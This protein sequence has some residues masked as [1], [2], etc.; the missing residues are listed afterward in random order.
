MMKK[1]LVLGAGLI[2]PTIAKDLADEFDVTI[3]DKDSKA[4]KKIKNSAIN[5]EIRDLKTMRNDCISPFDIVVG[6]LPGHLGYDAAKRILESGKNYVDISFAPE[7]LKDLNSLAWAHGV[8]CLI[9]FGVAPGLSHLVFGHFKETMKKINKY[10]IYVG[11]LLKFPGDHPPWY[12]KAPFSPADVIEEYT[13]PARFICNGKVTTL[14]ALSL[15]EILHFEPHGEF[16]AFL[17]DGVR[18]LL[19]AKNV[20]EIVEK[21]IRPIGY[22]DKIQLLI[23]SGFFSE[24]PIM[25]ATP[26]E[27]TKKLLI[28]SWKMHEYDQDMTLMKLK[29]KGID[30]MGQPME[31]SYNLRDYHDGFNSSMARTTGF[32]CA[33][34][35]RLIANNMIEEPGVY[36]PEEIGENRKCFN[37]VITDLKRHGIVLT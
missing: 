22:R 33:A 23:D 36:A 14:P 15:P 13:R 4:L 28:D 11:G 18:T 17:T 21:T 24:I 6:T 37:F 32:M 10:H 9:D 35:V 26:R 27:L 30:Y 34:G 19:S 8:R 7:N 20:D 29:A 16:E 12:Y 25:G 31:C 3:F 1:V 2:G 5:K